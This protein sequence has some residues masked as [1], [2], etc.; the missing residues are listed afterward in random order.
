MQLLAERSGG[1]VGGNQGSSSIR[2]PHPPTHK[3]TQEW[4]NFSPGHDG[5]LYFA[6]ELHALIVPRKSVEY[7]WKNQQEHEQDDHGQVVLLVFG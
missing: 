2:H 4:E 7:K 6:F 3:R 5:V 1:E